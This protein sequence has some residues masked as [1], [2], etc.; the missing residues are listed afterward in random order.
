MSVKLLY[1]AW[2]R[3]KAGLGEETVELPQNVKTVTDL[4]AWQ[5]TRGPQFEAA[6]EQSKVIRTAID[7]THVAHDAEISQAREIA[8]FPPVTGG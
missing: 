2:V 3:E 4:M 8:F 5:K 1:F 6:F 7:Q